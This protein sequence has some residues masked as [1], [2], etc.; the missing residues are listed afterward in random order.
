MNKEQTKETE[1]EANETEQR[2]QEKRRRDMETEAKEELEKAM[3]DIARQIV[4]EKYELQISEHVHL[5][6]SSIRILLNA[7]IF[8]PM[9][10]T[11][12]VLEVAG[13]KEFLQRIKIG[14]AIE[15]MNW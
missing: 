13:Q 7:I 5:V 2:R 3:S 8:D 14:R 15:C 11:L 1:E 12:P 4:E 10:A 6:E 9:Q